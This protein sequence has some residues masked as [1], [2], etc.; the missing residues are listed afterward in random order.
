MPKLLERV[1]H[2]LGRVQTIVRDPDRKP[3]PQIARDLRTVLAAGE[4]PRFY[5]ERLLYRNQ[6]G[7]VKAYITG[8]DA[9][10]LYGLKAKGPGWLRNFDDKALFDRLMRPSGLPLPAFLGSTRMGA[11]VP[12]SG[13][14][15]ALP[16]SADLVRE[17]TA[18]IEASP[19]DGVFAKPV[20]ANQG[21]GAFRV[22]AETLD[23]K[24]DALF[25]AVSNNDYLFQESVRQHEGMSTL[26]PGS[27]N[28]LR[29]LVGKTDGGVRLLSV[30]ARMG[31]DGRPVDNAHAGG[32]FVGVDI[33][34]GRLKT[35]GHQLYF[36]G[37]RRFA[38]HP[39][40][41]VAFEG[42]PVPRFDEVLDVVRRAHEWLPHPYSGWDIGVTPDGPV[43]VECN[44]GPY[45]LMMDV[46]HGGLK[47][48]ARLRSF[49][50]ESEV[51][52]VR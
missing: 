7:S 34:T 1:Q 50:E 6:S 29:V 38:Q 5:L 52:L 24:A 47:R 41:G 51:A 26:Y 22:T 23:A 30:V 35:Y 11:F 44:A 15:R 10:A 45:L 25:K 20:V 21:S 32:I 43:I 13:D 19:T 49:L 28:T 12:V 16:T 31:S 46:A 48:D 4:S 9:K 8:K 36:F 17:V 40:T 2:K 42:Y 37:G 3:V 27:L 39:D 18:L 14:V 33:A